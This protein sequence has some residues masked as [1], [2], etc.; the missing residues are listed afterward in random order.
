MTTHFGSTFRRA[1][2]LLEFLMIVGNAAGADDPAVPLVSSA[3][4]RPRDGLPNFL[5][6]AKTAGASL[7]V[8]Y[9]GGSITAQPGWRPKTLAHFQQTFP[10]ARFSEINAAIG[11]TGSDLGVYRLK[12]DVLDAEPDLLLIEFATNDSGAPPAQIQKSMEGIVRQTWKTRPQCDICF[13]YTI[14]ESTA[15]PLL[16]GKFPRAASLTEAIADHYGIPTI[17]L[18]MEVARLAREGKLVWSAPLPK[19][20]AEKSAL[21]ARVV[22]AADGVHPYPETGHELYFQAIVRS[23]GPIAAA[24]RVPGPHKLKSPLFADNYEN[25]KLIPIERATLSKAFAPIDLKTDNEFKYFGALMRSL[26][27]GEHPGDSVTFTF[28]GTTA[29]IYDVIGPSS[30]QVVI[31]VDNQPPR[32][33]SRF[34]PFCFLGYR[35][36]VLPIATALPDGPHRVKIEIH[37]EEP[38]R[39]KILGAK[40]KNLDRPERF[41]GTSFFP[42]AILLIG[43]LIK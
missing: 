41:H 7:K 11:G 33:V 21:G 42:G 34:D 9:L 30:G 29:A 2:F 25:A 19:S 24:S 27:R 31:T 32:V 36:G 13:V 3:E 39:T 14:T 8:A 28:Q 35:P 22:F 15:A 1:G 6:R 4:C 43:D 12:Q 10:T 40:S 17:H 18:A 26:Y 23:L 38:D 20:S 16:E 5:A 37:P